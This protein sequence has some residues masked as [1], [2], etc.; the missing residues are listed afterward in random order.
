LEV[1][2]Q[3]GSELEMGCV[4]QETMP[5]LAAELT[6][7]CVMMSCFRR[8]VDGRSGKELGVDIA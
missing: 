1:Q 2:R 3:S 7:C 6:A 5:F 4:G 8:E